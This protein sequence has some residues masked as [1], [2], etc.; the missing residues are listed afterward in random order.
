MPVV[1]EGFAVIHNSFGEGT[2]AK[3]DKA[4]KRLRVKF[5]AG[6]KIFVIPDAFADGNTVTVTLRSAT[7]TGDVLLIPA[8]NYDYNGTPFDEY[9]L[10][11]L[12]TPDGLH[13]FASDAYA[14]KDS[15][16]VRIYHVSD[17]LWKAE[18]LDTYTGMPLTYGRQ[19]HTNASDKWSKAFGYHQIEILSATG[20]NHFTSYQHKNTEFTAKDLFRAGD[21]FCAEQFPEFFYNGK[22]DNGYDFGYTVEIV[23]VTEGEAPTATIRIIRH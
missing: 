14:L 8:A 1:K 22:M 13:R 19:V 11:E 10:V 4:A 2:I 21:S 3:I 20:V 6:E 23:S 9:L 5:A 15:V 7:L 16:G 12:F 18:D 17:R